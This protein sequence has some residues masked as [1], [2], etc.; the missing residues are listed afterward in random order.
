MRLEIYKFC[1]QLSPL[2]E[3]D[4]RLQTA[5]LRGNAEIKL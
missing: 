5:K 1:I 2:L 4:L 3:P